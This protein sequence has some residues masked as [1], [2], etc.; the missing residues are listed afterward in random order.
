MGT[1]Y[2]VLLICSFPIQLKGEKIRLIVYCRMLANLEATLDCSRR[3]IERT[4]G[5]IRKK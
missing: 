1:F 5:K 4:C 2:R 3:D